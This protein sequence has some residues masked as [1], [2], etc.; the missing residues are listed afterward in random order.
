MKAVLSLIA[1]MLVLVGCGA[2]A[3]KVDPIVNEGI[4][5]QDS[6]ELHDSNGS[7]GP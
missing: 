2:L 5:D 3:D 7:G 4:V 6:I 1:G